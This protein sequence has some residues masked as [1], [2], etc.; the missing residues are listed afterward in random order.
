VELLLGVQKQLTCYI[1]ALVSNHADAEDVL[2]EANLFIWHHAD[3]YELGT[4]FAAW[5]SR[6]AYYQ[7]LNRRKSQ[8]GARLQFSNALVEQL[9]VTVARNPDWPSN[10]LKAFQQ[11]FDRL[12][13]QDRELVSLRYE[14]DAT[15]PGIARKVGRTTGA[16]YKALG[17]IRNSL[18]ECMERSLSGGR[19]T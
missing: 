1:R 15:V 13:E 12:S 8:R 17:R 3:E 7:V 10:D 9:A 5:A 4:N 6:I 16:V 18:I 14:P 11:C 19:R 2:Q